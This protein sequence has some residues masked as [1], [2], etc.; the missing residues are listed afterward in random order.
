MI[1]HTVEQVWIAEPDFENDTFTPSSLDCRLFRHPEFKHW[2]GY[3]RLPDNHPDAGLLKTEAD[4][5]YEVHGGITYAGGTPL[6]HWD[7]FDG[8]WLGFDCAHAGDYV[9]GWVDMWNNI[10]E[11]DPSAGKRIEAMYDAKGQLTGPFRDVYRT[12]DFARKELQHLAEQVHLRYLA[13]S[14]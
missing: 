5:F 14:N 12:I 7:L 4:R 13:A 11:L 10:I 8:S 6:S 2:C 9:P 1:A 3:V